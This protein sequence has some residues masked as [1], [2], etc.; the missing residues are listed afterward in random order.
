MTI[1]QRHLLHNALECVQYDGYLIVNYNLA[2]VSPP[3]ND[4]I[5]A[6]QRDL[7]KVFGLSRVNWLEFGT[8][9]EFI[10]PIWS[11]LAYSLTTPDIHRLSAF[12]HTAYPADR[13][14]YYLQANWWRLMTFAVYSRGITTPAIRPY[15]QAAVMALETEVE[16]LFATSLANLKDVEGLAT[17]NIE[18][19]N[20]KMQ[21]D[22]S[23]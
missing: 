2:A 8:L 19:F 9:A 12:I 10:V 13:L 1:N 17:I 22:L 7:S 11:R 16:M 6:V 4:F 15:Q 5:V 20:V 21:N 14:R 23:L 3:T 18:T